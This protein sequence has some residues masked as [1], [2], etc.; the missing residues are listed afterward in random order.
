MWL[1]KRWGQAVLLSLFAFVAVLVS[2]G[3]VVLIAWL[4]WLLLTDGWGIPG[5][6]AI[7]AAILMIGAY[8]WRSTS[9]QRSKIGAKALQNVACVRKV[10]VRH[11]ILPAGVYVALVVVAHDRRG[12][13]RALSEKLIL[14]EGSSTTITFHTSNPAA[15]MAGSQTSGGF[16]AVSYTGRSAPR[17]LMRRN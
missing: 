11:R 8:G 14:I 3:S 1:L 4:L 17:V 2:A 7:S 12:F 16:K 13:A 6:V 10:D 9:R 5:P 15:M